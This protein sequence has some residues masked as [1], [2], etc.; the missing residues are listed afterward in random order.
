MKTLTYRKRTRLGKL[1]D[2]LVAAVPALKPLTDPAGE[3]VAVMT[4][5]GDATV[6]VLQ[7]PDGADEQAISAVVSAHDPSTPSAFE[8]QQQTASANETTLGQRATA[9]LAANVAYLGHAA[10]PAGTLTA[11]QLSTV[12]RTMSD[13][14][15]ALTRQVDALIRLTLRVLDSTSG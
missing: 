15:D 3:L 12:V 6:T 7:V 10:I 2:E 13:Q 14:V 9:A 1:Q 5:S 8:Q 11:A 4:V